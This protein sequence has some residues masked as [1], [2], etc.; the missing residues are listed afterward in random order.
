MFLLAE[1][2]QISLTRHRIWLHHAL[3]VLDVPMIIIDVALPNVHMARGRLLMISAISMRGL[4][5][6]CRTAE[7]TGQIGLS[8]TWVVGLIES[9]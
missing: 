6:S 1:A 5:H 3:A 2:L 4:A 7:T 8:T 9:Y